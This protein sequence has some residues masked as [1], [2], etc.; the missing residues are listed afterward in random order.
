[1]LL[2]YYITIISKNK[3]SIKIFFKVLNKVL[4][5]FK[6]VKKCLKKKRKIKILTIL[7]SPHVNKN[8]QEQFETRFYF[9]QINVRY[10]PK[11][12]QFLIFLKKLKN[13][14]FSDIKIKIEFL[15]NKS[16]VKKTQTK[17]LNPNNFNLQFFNKKIKNSSIK[18]SKDQKYNNCFK[19]NNR[20]KQI[21]YL[22][23]IFDTY[24]NLIKPNV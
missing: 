9:S 21:Q 23:K 17:L 4:Q 20:F 19:K 13:Y 15:I 14:V 5:N 1:M 8:A 7:K 2:N 11:N 12:L 22:L 18:K 10:S 6:N 3:I 24:G 16:L